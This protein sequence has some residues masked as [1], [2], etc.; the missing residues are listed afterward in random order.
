MGDTSD[1]GNHA[2]DKS[3]RMRKKHSFFSHRNSRSSI[4]TK[5]M[6]IRITRGKCIFTRGNSLLAE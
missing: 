5:C 2:W 3:E 4:K 1:R 6:E